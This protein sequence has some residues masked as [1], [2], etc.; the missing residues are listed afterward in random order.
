LALSLADLDDAQ[1]MVAA[2]RISVWPNYEYKMPVCFVAR[3]ERADEPVIRNFA[4]KVMAFH[5]GTRRKAR[6]L[7]VEE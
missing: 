7:R 2:G 1:P 5:S 6:P 3:R 4:Q